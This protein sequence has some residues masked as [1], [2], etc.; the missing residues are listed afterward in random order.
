MLVPSIV[1][2][3]VALG[4][5]T[6]VSRNGYGVAPRV[7]YALAIAFGIVSA[8]I[9]N[10]AAAFVAALFLVVL[11]SITTIVDRRKIRVER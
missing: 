6:F 2:I 5:L 10:G 9:A 4:L 7:F 3:V 8:T 1:A 11:G